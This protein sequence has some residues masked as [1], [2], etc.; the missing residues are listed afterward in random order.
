MK[1]DRIRPII[2]VAL[3]SV[4][5]FTLVPAP[6]LAADSGVVMGRV[7]KSD[8]RTPVVGATI[9]FVNPATMDEIR[10]APTGDEGAFRVDAP[11]GSYIVLVET[12]TGAFLASES[13]AVASGPNRLL[14]FT[15]DGTVQPTVNLGAQGG[16]LSNLAK[17]LIVG[18]IV[19][20]AALVIDSA[21]DDSEPPSSPF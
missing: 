10:S 13:L 5:T 4:L 16:G 21:T 1:F 12:E 18:G 17:W 7:V 19:V 2:A 6:L 9:V 3:A 11:A 15:L 20:G 8:Q 14:S